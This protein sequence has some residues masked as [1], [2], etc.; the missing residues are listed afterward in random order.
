MMIM[1]MPIDQ[2]N[3]CNPSNRNLLK[4]P[5]LGPNLDIPKSLLLLELDTIART[6]HEQLK[7]KGRGGALGCLVSVSPLSLAFALP[8]F[9]P[10]L[11]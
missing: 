8:C 5:L 7:E 2:G 4:Q 10:G 11:F 1:I 3:T 6:Q 9:C